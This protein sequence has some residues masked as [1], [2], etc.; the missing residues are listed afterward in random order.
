MSI[1]RRMLERMRELCEDV[2][3]DDGIDPREFKKSRA[4]EVRKTDRRKTLQLCGQMA[5]TIQLC[6]GAAA[7]DVLR[8]VVV[9]GVEPCPDASRLRVVVTCNAAADLSAADVLG[10]LERASGW[11]RSEVA[12][13]ITRKRA[14][15]LAFGWRSP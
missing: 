13:A 10:R 6:L 15:G 14:P 11:L 8:R 2:G 12:V 9:D 4:K 1:D 7:D 3:P 5:R